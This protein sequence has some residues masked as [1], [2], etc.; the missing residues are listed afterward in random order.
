[1]VSDG[2]S[3]P[4]VTPFAR[5]TPKIDARG[6]VSNLQQWS[7]D[8]FTLGRH[9]S[10]VTV[11]HLGD[12]KRRHWTVSHVKLHR[13]SATALTVKDAEASQQRSALTDGE[14]RGTIVTHLNNVIEEVQG[15]E[16]SERSARANAIKNQH[17]ERGTKFILTTRR[18]VTSGQHRRT[19][20][21]SRGNSFVQFT[22]E[23]T[24][25]VRE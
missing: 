23:T 19:E 7:G 20:N 24:V 22:L 12:S 1:V 18:D 21:H 15:L 2:R 6:R 9:E 10:E 16:L 17:G 14:M 5:V 8:D 25:I 13:N 3:R 11:A 4:L